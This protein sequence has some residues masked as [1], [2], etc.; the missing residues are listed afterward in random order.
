MIVDQLF[1]RFPVLES[2][3]LLL[4]KVE[5]RHLDGLF[6]I[7]DN[8]RVF[9]YCGIVPKHNKETVAN[10]IGHF[11]RDYNKR[12]KVKWGIFRK[13]ESDALVGI[14]DTFDWN[15]RVDMVTVGF[16]LAEKVW[17][18]G[19][20]TEAVGRLKKYL[21]EDIG[22]NR[23]Q[24]EV[25]PGNGNSKRVLLKNGFLLE[26]T[27]RQAQIWTGKGIVDLEIYGCL[28]EDYITR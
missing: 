11:E 22:V 7:F 20:A 10:M 12:F 26:G 6:E 15:Q 3:H 14:I 8:E 9:E 13:Q 21:F 2:D 19:I 16:Y 1:D 5:E 17:G 25:M 24:A 4:K 27:L 28:R 23:I 18:Q